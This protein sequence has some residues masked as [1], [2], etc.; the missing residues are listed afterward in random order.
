MTE[1]IEQV[2]DEEV[3]A[4]VWV[5]PKLKPMF[6]LPRGA[7]QYRGLYGGR[8]SAKSR[9]AAKMAA[10]W[11]YMEPL[12]VLTTREIQV[13]IKESFHAELK[14][15]IASEP[16]LA[17]SYDVGENYIY[18]RITGT[19][20]LFRGLRHNISTIRS[21]AGIGLTIVEEA[22]D[23]PQV[24]WLALQ[25][26]VFREPKSELW[27]IWN[28]AKKGSPVDKLFRGDIPLRNS[29]IVQMNHWDNPKF[30]AGLEELRVTQRESLDPNM[31]S[32]I[33]EGDYLE[34]SDAQILAGKW[35]VRDFEVKDEWDG[36]YQGGDFGFS[37]DPTAAVRVY[38]DGDTLYISHEA[39]KTGLELDD[40][41][42]YIC[43]RIPDFE[44]TMTRWDN[45]R[46]ESISHI[47]KPER[48]KPLPRSI[49][50]DKWK[51]S[52]EDGIAFLRSFKRIVVHTR[53]RETQKEMRNYSYKIDRL[54][55]DVTS[56][57]VD[58]FNHYIDAIRYAVT[59]IIRRSKL[60]LHNLSR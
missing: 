15:A 45:A 54:T 2:E 53:C 40:T 38:I 21:M 46:P 60:N 31:Y 4:D 17:A 1:L 56:V 51:G 28:P 8:G 32:H 5:P 49:A 55:Q 34:N 18:N 25:A 13:S 3:W 50:V 16:W 48:R 30:P 29:I 59:P 39:G 42:E 58:A 11:G 35:E 23:V 24:S 36:P 7:V 12:R 26:T 19:E 37:Q 33:W 6:A 44:K 9:T 20:F 27:A 10:V 52:V 57:I 22:E 47:K 43:S 14:A 41:G